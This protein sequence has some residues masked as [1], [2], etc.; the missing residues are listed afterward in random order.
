MIGVFVDFW[1]VFVFGVVEVDLGV[2]VG[3]DDYCL[4]G[5]CGYGDGVDMVVF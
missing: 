5:V 4:V 3:L 2:C 1:I